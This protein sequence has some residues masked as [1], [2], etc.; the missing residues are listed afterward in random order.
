MSRP[1]VHAIC[2]AYVDDYARLNP[3]AASEQGI[4]GHDDAL[5]DLSPDGHR[6][7]A[8]LA[9]RALADISAARAADESERVARA[10]FAE[11]VGLQVE[12]HEAGLPEAELNVIASPVQSIRWVF[13]LMATETAEDWARIARRLRA[14]PAALGGY[15]QALRA[16]AG[17]GRVAAVRQVREV[18]AQCEAWSAPGG[19]FAALPGS[20]RVD[21]ALRAELEAAARAAAG[22]YAELG[23]FLRDE[24]APRAAAGD[25][26]GEE[27]YALWSRTFLGARLDLR[28]VYAWGWEEFRRVEEE[29]T[30]ISGRIR[31]GAGPAEAAAAL[32]ADPRHLVRGQD[33]FQAWMRELS[34]R[35]LA[36]LRGRHFDIP[37]ELMRLDCRIAPPG[38]GS[39]AY[40]TNP[41]EDFSRPGTMWWSLPEGKEEFSTWR[42][43]STVYHEGVPG[44]H[45]QIGT[46]VATPG[47]NRFQRLACFVDGHGEGWALYAERL[48]REFGYLDDATSLGMLNKSLFRAARVVL[49]I[50]LHLRLGIPDGS[51]FHEG[52]R[53]TPELGIEFLSTRTLTDPARAADEVNRYLGWPGQAASYKVG[54]KLWLELREEARARQGA[55]FDLKDFHTRALRSGPAGLDTMRDLMAGSGL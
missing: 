12:L 46:A 23:A 25:A 15:R 11:R 36:D 10:V 41:A 43:A 24:L 38:G 50:G 7:R 3:I 37:D 45:L 8:E 51:G 27:L 42:E 48:M 18:V 20:A 29:M 49:D 16:A 19:F 33:G 6:A 26:V 34:G 14:V 53:W 5:P 55:A 28:E 17:R 31:P 22:A 32:D 35:A 21:E 39:G 30:E 4:G 9:R 1:G 52:E 40:Y 54:E 13:D 2:D 47:L 44:H